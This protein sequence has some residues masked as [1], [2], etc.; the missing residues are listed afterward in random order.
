MDFQ[1]NLS[2]TVPD[3]ENQVDFK[4]LDN[5]TIQ[6]RIESLI[7]SQK[8]LPLVA[9]IVTMVGQLSDQYF[10]EFELA[11][12]NIIVT[13]DTDETDNAECDFLMVNQQLPFQYRND[14]HS[15]VNDIYDEREYEFNETLI[16]KKIASFFV[17]L[18]TGEEPEACSELY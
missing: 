1:D 14:L 4:H 15:V 3:W 8:L 7:Q 9:K 13:K 2:E 12:Y 10:Y 6:S 17:T 11:N 16:L 5:Y 18:A